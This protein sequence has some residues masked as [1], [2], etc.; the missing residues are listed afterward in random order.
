MYLT[1]SI[2]FHELIE[3]LRFE[4]YETKRR[5]ENP[6]S[7]KLRHVLTSKETFFQSPKGNPVQLSRICQCLTIVQVG[8]KYSKNDF[9]TF[10]STL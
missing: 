2:Q 10:I 6:E 3:L 4:G 8:K 9:F 7:H 5:E 1:K